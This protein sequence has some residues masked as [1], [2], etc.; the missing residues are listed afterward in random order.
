MLKRSFLN[1]DLFGAFLVSRAVILFAALTAPILVADLNAPH[2]PW[3]NHAEWMTLLHRAFHN[4]DSGWYEQIARFGYEH[5]AFSG[6][7]QT[8]WGYFPLFPLLLRVVGASTPAGALLGAVLGYSGLA[9]VHAIVVRLRD[10]ET[11]ARTV[12]LMCFYPISFVLSSYRPEGLLLLLSA[13]TY[14]AL[15]DERYWLAGLFGFLTAAPKG[16][17]FAPSR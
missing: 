7:R 2:I 13:A 5:R 1:R 8:N 16:F 17:C 15:M 6:A 3:P 11:A 12:K 10:E 14:L 4:A 9:L